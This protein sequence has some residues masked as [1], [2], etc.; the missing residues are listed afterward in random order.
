MTFKRRQ[1]DRRDRMKTQIF[2]KTP[3]R[4][5]D[6]V[7][8]QLRPAHEIHLVDCQRDMGNAQHGNDATVSFGLREQSL[9]GVGQKYGSLS[10]RRA[11]RHIARILLVAWGIG[12]DEAASRRRKK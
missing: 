3:I 11:S 7:E 4:T 12:D 10:G 6:L 9:A 2:G 5:L 1:R 8:D